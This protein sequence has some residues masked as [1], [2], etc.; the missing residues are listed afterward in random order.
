MKMRELTIEL[1]MEL[2]TMIKM[3]G[4]PVINDVK[5]LEVFSTYVGIKA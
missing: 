5:E 3:K 1:Y 2:R 4:A